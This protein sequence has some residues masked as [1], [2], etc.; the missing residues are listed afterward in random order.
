ME[1]LNRLLL[2]LQPADNLYIIKENLIAF[3]PKML[4]EQ[5]VIKEVDLSESLLSIVVG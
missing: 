1:I 2:C 4:I 5:T 3:S